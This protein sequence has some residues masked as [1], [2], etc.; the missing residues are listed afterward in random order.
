MPLGG[1]GPTTVAVLWVETV[2]S[3]L[4]VGGRFY[5]RQFRKNSAG[6][7]DYALISSWAL[8]FI[9]SVFFTI[10]AIAGFGQHVSDIGA[11]DIQEATFYELCGQFAVALAMGLS[12]T[13]VALFLLRIITK[14]WQK[15]VLWGWIGIMMFLSVLLA[16]TCFTQC[17]PVQSLWDANIESIACPLDLTY[18]A[19]VMCSFSAAMDFFL[20]FCPYYVLKDLNMKQKEKWTIIV[21]LSLGVFAGIFGIIRTAGLGVLAETADYLYATADSVMFTSS[22]LT[23]TFICVSLPVFRPL[24]QAL[25]STESRKGTYYKHSTGGD[26]G[27]RANFSRMASKNRTGARP[28]EEHAM[29]TL[30]TATVVKEN[31]ADD[32][33][34]RSA[35]VDDNSDRSILE[36]EHGGIKRK[37]EFTVS[38]E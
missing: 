24:I 33:G 3:A 36:Q 6:I 20:A 16:I 29:G 15:I 2:I 14:F 27:D 8:M 25:A 13:G 4:C 18:V 38:Y 5:T 17:Y 26:L 1:K 28:D 9:F 12:K 21:S 35:W 37:Q 22:E 34:M 23:L 32:D 30:T 7:D 10:S 11:Q 31:S 19:Y